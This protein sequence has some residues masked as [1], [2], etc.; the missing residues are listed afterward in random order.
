VS[1]RHNT[2]VRILRIILVLRHLSIKSVRKNTAHPR[3]RR[4]EI[5]IKR[6]LWS[7]GEV[8]TKPLPRSTG[9]LAI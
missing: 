2:G 5:T 6:K 8:R 3:S 4:E 9:S 1:K 7:T